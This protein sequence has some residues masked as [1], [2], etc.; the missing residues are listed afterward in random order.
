LAS[1]SGISPQGLSEQSEIERFLK[2]A[3]IN[4]VQKGAIGG[5]SDAWAVTLKVKSDLRKG[6]F[7]FVDRPRPKRLPQSYQYELAAYELSKVLGVDFIPPLVPKTVL[8]MKGSLQIFMAGCIT[9]NKRRQQKLDPPDPKRFADALDEM[10][11]F[12]NLMYCPR[13]DLGDIL[14]QTATWRV[15]RVDFMEAFDPVAEL[16]PEAEPSRCSIRLYKS[17]SELNPKNI[18]VM[19]GRYLNPDEIKSLLERRIIVL[20]KLDRLIKAKGRDAV[21]FSFWNK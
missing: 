15:F 10:N 8:K 7:K 1:F 21:L 13:E 2:A 4:E 5:R 6:V 3:E 17:L 14:I 20:D 9:E 16:L 12:E 19:L 11:V 18:E